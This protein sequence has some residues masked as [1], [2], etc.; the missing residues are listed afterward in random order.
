MEMEGMDGDE[1]DGWR[2]R[3]WMEMEGMDGDGGDLRTCL[4]GLQHSLWVCV[5]DTGSLHAREGRHQRGR[6]F[7]KLLTPYPIS[8]DIRFMR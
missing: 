2:W 7:W 6:D 4:Q 3:R 5:G 1:G 8:L